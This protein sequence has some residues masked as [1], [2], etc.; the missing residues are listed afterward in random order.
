[1]SVYVDHLHPTIPCANWRYTQA[2]HM[3]ADT[4]G[5]LH[6]LAAKIGM[7]RCWYDV[8][9]QHYDLTAH[10]RAVALIHGAKEATHSDIR[11]WIDR[12]RAARLKARAERVKRNE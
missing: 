5:E 11:R 6:P 1:M 3:F 12:T 7:K 8:A 2:C 10:K 9:A 4:E